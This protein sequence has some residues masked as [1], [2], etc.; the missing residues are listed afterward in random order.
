M[1]RMVFD[2]E[3]K[4]QN[5]QAMKWITQLLEYN[6]DSMKNYNEIHIYQEESLIILEWEQVPYSK[7]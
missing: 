1:N 2:T 7:E 5:E 4:K 3:D 6:K